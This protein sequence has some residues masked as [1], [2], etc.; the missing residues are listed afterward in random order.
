MSRMTNGIN[1]ITG[2]VIGISIRLIFLALLLILLH[3]GVA[4]G[5]AFGHEIFYASAA[6]PAPG[7]DKTV[8]VKEGSDLIH[9]AGLLKDSGL[10]T[11]EYSFIIQ[12]GFFNYKAKP[13][14]YTLN[15]SM[16]SREIL[17]MMNGE[18]Q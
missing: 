10:I 13:G 12:A 2:A 14:S 17:Q 16:T 18:D 3:E 4:R 15:T 11:N 5:Y 6:E 8:T 9:T 7:R 1:Q